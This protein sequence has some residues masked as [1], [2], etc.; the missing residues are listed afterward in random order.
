MKI[1]I[2]ARFYGSIGKGLGRYTQKL[3]QHLEQI[4]SE[5]Q[6]VVFLRREN[7]DD[8]QPF[9]ENFKKVMADYPWYSFS[10]QIFFPLTLHKYKLDLVHFPH[11]NVPLLY[12]GNFVL[13]VHDL[14]LTH[15][16]TLRGTM[17]NPVVY[18]IKYGAYKLAILSAIYRCRRI[19]TVSEFTKGDIL[20]VYPQTKGKIAV[21]YEACD[22]HCS[23]GIGLPHLILEKY[24]I[25]KPYLLYVGNAYPHKNLEKL[26]E[27]FEII[28]AK[29][30]NMQLALVGKEDFFYARLKKGVAEKNIAGVHFL[31][32]VNDQD[33]DVIYRFAEAYVF[34]SLYEGFGLPPLEAMAKGTVVI[35]SKHACMQEILG[36]AAFYVDAKDANN[37]AAGII[38]VLDDKQLQRE[39]TDK[40]YAQVGKYDWKK[41]ATETLE[42]YRS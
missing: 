3:I 32:F 1:G 38:N 6:Y 33:L 9:N 5:N 28:S 36:P 19:I 15:F 30:P 4:D 35:S 39:L 41:M 31:G 42:I 20:N 40:G 12:F 11:F 27:A 8:Y 29:Y 21:T 34:P 18:W 26:I 7:F 25:I 22:Q 13:T 24:G 23:V 10:E 14:I 17:L 2:D 37:F 16:P